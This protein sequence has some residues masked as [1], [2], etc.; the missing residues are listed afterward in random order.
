[1][2]VFFRRISD[3]QTGAVT[4]VNFGL[5]LVS[6]GG[7]L[8]LSLYMARFFGLRELGAYGLAFGCVMI[9]V[10][11]FGLRL[12]YMLAREI[13]D[14]DANRSPVAFRATS[15]FYLFNFALFCVPALLVLHASS[16]GL[17][18][19][20]ELIIYALCCLEAY[21]NLMYEVL[22]SLSRS[23]AAN[24]LIFVR[25]GAWTIPAIAL[26]WIFPHL[27]TAGFVLQCW[28]LCLAASVAVSLWCVRRV[29]LQ[30]KVSSRHIRAWLQPALRQVIMV[31]VGSVAVT[32]GGYLDR[33]VLAHNLSIE[34]VGVA[35]FYL[36]FTSAV[37]SLIQSSTLATGFPRLIIL[38][39]EA[40][41]NKYIDLFKHLFLLAA[42]MSA[43]VLIVL[44]FV[45]PIFAR[46]T[47]KTA[48][49]AEMP[50]FILL[51]CATWI[52]THAESA[53]YMLYVEHKNRA[54]WT[55][56]LVFL[57]TS[58]SLNF[59]LIPRYGVFGLGVAASL[60]A[61]ALLAW[62]LWF[63]LKDKGHLMGA[64]AKATS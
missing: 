63:A 35:S 62:R 18:W 56:N 39:K 15:S 43:G 1:M 57:A 29:L 34:Q 48:L 37:L 6:L 2:R 58:S 54:V 3:R 30:R 46:F 64:P 12:D 9:A 10:S 45:V 8:L 36:S 40:L 24:I 7:K 55:G 51:L 20:T 21:A 19:G 28:L 26:S 33:F 59:A 50:A 41:L 13:A 16:F 47:H 23:T 32:I 17:D 42:G 22:I 27:R 25:G 52:R 4:A 44:G 49:V 61:L 31:W 14:F 38:R 60:S 5:R 53:Y 11:V